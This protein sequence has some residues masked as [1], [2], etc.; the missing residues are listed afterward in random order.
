MSVAEFQGF[1]DLA[2][3]LE[4]VAEQAEASADLAP[5]AFDED[6]QVSARSAMARAKRNVPVDTGRLRD[7]IEVR[8]RGPMNYAIGS[9]VA[10]AAYVEKGTAP[11]VITGDPLH[12]YA[13]GEEVFATR[14]EH[15]GTPA[16]PY[17]RPALR[18]TR[19]ELVRR[20]GRTLNDL[21]GEAMET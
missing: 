6:V 14:V 16:Q 18:E 9:D 11:H 2:E 19:S 7:S 3:Q 17:L 10:Y 12:F 21:F 15:P 8:R 1:E 20:M 4:Q 13:D 5:D